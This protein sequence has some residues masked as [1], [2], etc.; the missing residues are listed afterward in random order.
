MDTTE[1]HK[2][3]APRN[4]ALVMESDVDLCAVIRAALLLDGHRVECVAD[5]AAVLAWRSSVKPLPDELVLALGAGEL[6]PDWDKLQVA[7]D[8]DA[9]LSRA[10]LIVLL[11]IR[12]GLTFPARARILQKPFAMEKLLGLVAADMARASGRPV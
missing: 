6:D 9:V 11:T 8:E 3:S 4:L 10:A 7:L 2:R 12:N 1:T 5:C